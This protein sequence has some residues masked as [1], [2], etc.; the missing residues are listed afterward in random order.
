M[1]D[2]K[3]VIWLAWER[4][5]R[6][7]TI[8]DCLDI[9]LYVETYK[10]NSFLRYMILAFRSIAIINKQ[11]PKV[12]IVQNPSLILCLLALFLKLFFRFQL[13][14]DAHNEGVSPYI[15]NFKL[16]VVLTNLVLKYANYTIVTNRFLADIVH[17]KQGRALV[18]PDRVP[19]P[20]RR[21]LEKNKEQAEEKTFLLICTHAEDEPVQQILDAIGR[22]NKEIKLLITGKNGPEYISRYKNV[23]A[24]V[25][26]TGFLSEEEYFSTLA[27]CDCVIDLSLM[28]YCLV[29]GAYEA[30]AYK[31]PMILS[32]NPACRELFSQGVV[33]S[34]ENTEAI[35]VAIQ[36]MLESLVGLTDEADTL[37]AKLDAEWDGHS[38]DL[39]KHLGLRAG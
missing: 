27:T 20:E 12:L 10:G 17:E 35:K 29:C 36:A 31:R 8:C 38:D 7:E 4:H 33:Y 30:A 18:L 37:K 11:R 26:F 22:F 5:R 16:F 19:E 14:V 28:P 9:P 21:F 23:P 13:V 25:R 39:L 32:D 15:N 1:T 6:T 2:K 3:S 24:N 34:A